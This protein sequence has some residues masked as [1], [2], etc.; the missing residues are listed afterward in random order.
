MCPYGVTAQRWFAHGFTQGSPSL[1]NKANCKFIDTHSFKK[2][3]DG[4]LVALEMLKVEPRQVFDTRAM[5]NTGLSAVM[6]DSSALKSWFRQH[7]E[8]DPSGLTKALVPRDCSR[9]G[10]LAFERSRQVR[11]PPHSGRG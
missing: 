1:A 4:R 5:I 8:R 2:S 9:S 7:A 6:M 10:D 11:K 3:A